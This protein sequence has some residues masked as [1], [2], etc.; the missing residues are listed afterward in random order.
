[1]TTLKSGDW[2]DRRTGQVGSH[3]DWRKM[4]RK[5]EVFE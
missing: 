2:D 1:M 5:K 4:D 3:C